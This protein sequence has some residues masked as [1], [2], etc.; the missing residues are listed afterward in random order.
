MA[1]DHASVG[2]IRAPNHLGDLILAL[3]ALRAAG[4]DTVVVAAGLAPLVGLEFGDRILPFRRGRAGFLAAA[5][6]L[7]ARRPRTGVLLPPSL[8]SALLFR[9][10]GVR[11]LRGLD[12]DGRG[13]LLADRVA[14]ERFDALHRAAGY[15]MLVTDADPE[16]PPVPTLA[17]AD[18]DRARAKA[19]VSA[20]E[21]R[22]VGLFP[23]SNASSRRWPRERFRELARRLAQGGDRV[24]VFGG[25]EE[26]A[27]TTFVAGEEALDLGGRT[28][29]PLL[30]AALASCDILVTNDSGPMHLAGAVGTPVVA[31]MGAGD[32]AATGPL[33]PVRELL[34][35]ADLPCV[36]C[37]KNECPRT[38]IGFLLPEA[39]RE[40]LRL[41]EVPVVLRAA[42]PTR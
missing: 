41:I 10:G 35:R 38:G 2:A 7:R 1:T 14:R 21:G 36:P 24:V 18:A 13:V 19:L 5:K 23:G 30:A 15:L 17:V 26:R 34:F 37:V 40:C 9:A 33:G 29:L 42:A 12:T 3:P 8:S 6:A 31:M 20:G 28:D 25:P 4:A 39:E 22:L 16:T 11:R 32:P 27:L